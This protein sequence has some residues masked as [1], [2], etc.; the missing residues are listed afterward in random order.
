MRHRRQRFYNSSGK[1]WTTFAKLWKL[2]TR[3]L[4]KLGLRDRVQVVII[5]YEAGIVSP[6]RISNG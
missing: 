3:I 6:R 4:T 5:A 2:S 1:R